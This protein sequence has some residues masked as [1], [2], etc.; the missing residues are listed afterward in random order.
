MM[1]IKKLVTIF[2]IIFISILSLNISKPAMAASRDFY[3][4]SNNSRK[5]YTNTEYTS[6]INLLNNL[7][8]KLND[9]PESFVYEFKGVF[10]NYND[11]FNTYKKALNSGLDSSKAFDFAL[12]NSL[13]IHSL[14]CIFN[15]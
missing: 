3:D 4:F 10:F 12:K 6:N 8:S 14:P 13:L 7:I 5:I 15:N 1:N 11:L 9:H 2:C